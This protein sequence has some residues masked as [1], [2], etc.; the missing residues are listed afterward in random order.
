MSIL[1]KITVILFI[2][3]LSACQTHPNQTW[4]THKYINGS[5]YPAIYDIAHTPFYFIKNY[6]TYL[7]NDSCIISIRADK[8][9]V[10]TYA[11]NYSKRSQTQRL[12]IKDGQLY[13]ELWSR[14]SNGV[15]I[16][17]AQYTRA[18]ID[19]TRNTMF[20][21]ECAIKVNHLADSEK[22]AF[23]GFFGIEAEK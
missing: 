20:A 12:G 10:M 4:S 1:K 17:Y 23:Q 15:L 14:D 18:Q 11:T 3:V 22:S 2:L 16:E 6:P 9:E 7:S 5:N 21:R 19:K 8:K 13:A